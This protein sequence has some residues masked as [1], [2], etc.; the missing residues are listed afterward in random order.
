MST[1]KLPGT[2]IPTY[3]HPEY[4]GETHEQ[5]EE[6]TRIFGTLFLPSIIYACL[7][8]LLLY[9]NYN[10]ITMPLFVLATLGYCLYC[11]QKLHEVAQKQMIPY[12][13]GMI[14]LGISTCCT[15][16]LQLQTFN[17]LGIV[18]LLL[19]MLLHQYFDV[20]NW[21]ITKY[22]LTLCST[23]FSPLSRIGDFF[24]DMSCFHKAHKNKRNTKIGYV[25]LGI[26]IAI[27]FLIFVTVLFCTADAV[28]ADV[29][30]NLFDFDFDMGNFF[31]IA[32]TFVLVLLASYGVMRFLNQR[33]ITDEIPDLRRFEPI[34]ANTILSLTA[35]VYLLFSGIQIIYLFIGNMTLPDGY[36]YAEYAREGF[37]QLL[38]VCVMN[39]ALVLFFLGCF[40]ENLFLKILLTII[41][42]CTYI[43]LASSA[44]R[45]CMYI[46][47]YRL[48]FLRIFV[49]WFLALL[50][51]LLAGI[52]FLIYKRQFPMFRYM[53]VV[54]SVF[55]I[56]FSF[57]HPD[58]WIAKYNLAHPGPNT[59]TYETDDEYL[60]YL[61]AD[62]APAIAES[63]QPW[64]THYKERILEDYDESLRKFNFSS[65]NAYRLFQK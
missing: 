30:S 13:V 6:R 19:C 22:V 44:L 11:I 27:P 46:R 17:F 49:L 47:E 8:T 4:V 2:S 5:K 31:G 55:Y 51:I 29:I 56:G 50:A 16:S 3:T 65:W 62:A 28:F 21:T 37:F 58:Y 52:I 20:R 10:S 24:N 39:I 64:I 60:Q 63:N 57:A 14:F 15:D 9:E 43:M 53:L 26:L 38:F 36:T 33:T 7:Y 40:K 23:L 54:V 59:A 18:L 12:A 32:F 42:A 35:V 25:L 41:S 48:T 45:M 34:V 61:S 1:D